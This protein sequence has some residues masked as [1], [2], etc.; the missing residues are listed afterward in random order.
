MNDAL[1][2]R[3]KEIAASRIF[4]GYRRITVLLRREGWKV[5]SKRVYRLYKEE[6]TCISSASAEKCSLGIKSEMIDGFR[7]RSL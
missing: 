5:N 4:F 2:H 3:I 6:E 7:Y 1:R